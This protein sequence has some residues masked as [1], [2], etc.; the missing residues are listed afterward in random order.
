MAVAGLRGTGDWG[1]D[2]RPK[3]F[4][5]MILWRNPNG[6][7]PIF[8][9]MGKVA[10]ESTDD[11]EFSWWDEPND[12]V[13]LTVNGD[14]AQAGTSIT[15]TG[16]D[17]DA[18]PANRALNWGSAQHLKAG[19]L[20][21]VQPSAD[22]A[23]FDHELVEVVSVTSSTVFTVTR[24][25]A[26][27]TAP[28]GTASIPDGSKLL[29]QSSSYAEGTRAPDAATRNPIKY[30]NY[31]QIFKDTY[32]ITGTAEKT[33]TRTGDPVNNDKKRKTWDHSNKIEW[34]LMF[35]RR[36]E[37]TGS[38]GK[39]KRTMGGLREMIPGQN[40]KIFSGVGNLTVESWLDSV[41]KVFD[42]DSRA[43]DERMCFCGNEALNTLN[44]MINKDPNSRIDF[45]P[46]IKVYGWNFREYILPQGRL[47]LRTHPLLNRNPL[48]TKSMFIVDFSALKWR[49]MRGRDTRFK[50]NVQHN[51][52]DTRKGLWMTEAGFE[53]WH[54]GLTCAYLGGMDSTVLS[55]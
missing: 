31:T 36:W 50:D 28:V 52:E 42:W 22:Q 11:P 9:F 45:G 37:G 39:P 46:V 38:N 40:T 34:S 16:T 32:E 12:N 4:R 19:D 21:L 23:T 20:L 51:D 14:V 17:P 8:A 3:N 30:Y 54:G 55:T 41:Y 18:D 24:G 5:E 53:I 7:A 49:P 48:Y 29:L 27:T 44:K 33:R 1:P 2:E 10:K 25:A 15:V 6:S 47:L 35:G 13:I 26:G 43:G